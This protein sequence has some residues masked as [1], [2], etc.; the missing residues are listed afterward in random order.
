MFFFF[1][2]WLL[3]IF[4]IVHYFN[5]VSSPYSF[6]L[7]SFFSRF[8]KIWIH[9]SRLFFG[10]NGITS[11]SPLASIVWFPINSVTSPPSTQ[12]QK[13]GYRKKLKNAS[14]CKKNHKKIMEASPSISYHNCFC[15][16]AELA[17]Y[18]DLGFHDQTTEIVPV[19]RLEKAS[20]P[21]SGHRRLEEPSTELRG[22][23]CQSRDPR[24]PPPLR[25]STPVRAIS[26]IQVM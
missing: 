21:P 2:S 13:H 5:R 12:V 15:S 17:Q 20:S 1:L 26:P 24:V 7:Y 19:G 23:G 18:R 8:L 9:I 16:H 3:Y 25:N 6:H 11:V 4:I 14:A 22:N 10:V